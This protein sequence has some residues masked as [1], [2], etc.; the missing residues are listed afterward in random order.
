MATAFT[1]AMLSKSANIAPC[2]KQC[3]GPRGWC[4][5]E[6]TKAEML[7]AWQEREE[8]ARELLRANPGN[9]NFTR[10]LTGTGKRLKRARFEAMQRVFEEFVSQLE[11]RIKD[12]HHAGLYEHLKRMDLSRAG[13]RAVSSTSTMKKVDCCETWDSFVIGESSGSA[14]Q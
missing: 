1:E 12:G 2:A 8:A 4:C 9:S 14:L 3:Q 7:A 6:G 13:D 10:T 5:S 11:V